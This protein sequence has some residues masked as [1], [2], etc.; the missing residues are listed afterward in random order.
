MNCWKCGKTLTTGDK[1]FSGLC[2]GC[3][4][5]QQ[6]TMAQG[7][8]CPRCGKVKAPFIMECSCSPVLPK[9]TYTIGEP[10]T[11]KK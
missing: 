1:P 9:L 11:E 7:W 3:S 5:W 8:I 2:R 6:S 10:Q 4:E